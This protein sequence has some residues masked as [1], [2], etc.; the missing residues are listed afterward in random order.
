VRSLLKAQ[1][2]VGPTLE[3]RARL[4][5]LA[6]LE[7]AIEAQPQPR[8]RLVTVGRHRSHRPVAVS[9]TT[10]DGAVRVR[11]VKVCAAP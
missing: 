10:C 3:A 6:A 4:A 1:Q 8:Q 5:E 9:S 11:T 2:L 7:R